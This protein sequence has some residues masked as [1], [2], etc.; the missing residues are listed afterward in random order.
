MNPAQPLAIA[1][2]LLAL[3]I[4][5]AYLHRR[6]KT[7]KQV[8][9]AILFRII[10]GPQ[11]PTSRA[12]AKPRHLLSLLLVLIALAGL[13]AALADL[14]R[15][16][17]Q[18]RA[19]VVVLDTSASMGTRSVGDDQSR[20]DV[21]VEH[22]ET[23]L[24]RLGPRDR[25]A[26]VTAG[27]TPQVKLGFTEDHGRVL[28]VARGL[29]PAGTSE[30]SA[31][32][33]RIADAMCRATEDAAIVLISDGVG[34][35]AP[36][37][38]CPIEHVAVGRVG[39]NVG[40]TGLSVRE[41][42]ALGLAEVYVAVTADRDAEGLVEVGIE[43]DGHLMDVISIDVP[44]SGDAKKLHRMALPPGKRVTARL[45][46]VPVDTLAA[47]DVA[48]TPRRI[49]GRVSVL[50]ISTTRISFTAEALRLHPR[51]DLTVTG[52]N[53]EIVDPAYD[54]IVMEAE[55]PVAELP[56]APHVLALGTD[57]AA[58]GVTSPG[59]VAEPEIVRWDFD[60]ALFRFVSF[61]RV[62]L[63]NA[64]VLKPAEGQT[65]LLDA[66]AGSL[67]VAT[68]WNERDVIV[69]G[70]SPHASDF[71]LRVGFVNFIANA[72]E[73][74]APALP[75]STEQD[76]EFALASTEARVTPP[77]QIAGTTRG[78]F[79]G[80]VRKDWPVWELLVWAATGL[81]LAEWLLPALAMGVAPLWARLRSRRRRP[82]PA[83][84]AT[85]KEAG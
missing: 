55:R 85:T 16:G 24:A 6:R 83:K 63:P 26:L 41:A 10:A 28:E 23:S 51:V 12:M 79:S 36:S 69:F 52:P 4:I 67:A 78:D 2:G 70:F 11:T 42:D 7:P 65:S 14:Q 15:Q 82:R 29:S 64:R 18:P 60:D 46:N 73:W 37:T 40:I 30:E 57:P 20:L 45:M 75:P 61:D 19:Y 33:L 68:R 34:V 74:A 21:G 9:S 47:D 43:L 44:A 13:V 54:L 48:W 53:D 77:P 39:P 38:R 66:E 49:G 81:L 17:E 56:L 5:A 1:L 58:F 76:D 31:S 84:P 22:L 72:V 3:P 62:Q 50:L 8:P 32:A 27:G 25:V 59:A 71:V 35:N 80:P